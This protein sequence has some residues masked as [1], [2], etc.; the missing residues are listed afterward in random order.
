[1]IGAMMGFYSQIFS[2]TI[3]EDG[4]DLLFCLRDIKI[5]TDSLT[6]VLFIVNL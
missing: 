4:K 6:S 1:V 3:S 5:S 2:K